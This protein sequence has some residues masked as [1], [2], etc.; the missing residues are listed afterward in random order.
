[1]IKYIILLMFMAIMVHG[2]IV[3]NIARHCDGSIPHCRRFVS[4]IYG[5]E[6]TYNAAPSCERLPCA[7]A[8]MACTATC[9]YE[10]PL[11][12]VPISCTQCIKALYGKCCTC[13][14]PSNM[15]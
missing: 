10:F 4:S 6:F 14:L 13:V 3:D 11:C 7:A 12:T 2:G 1:M 15:C 5:P 8:A 9:L